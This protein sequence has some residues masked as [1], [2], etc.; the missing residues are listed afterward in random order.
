MIHLWHLPFDLIHTLSSVVALYIRLSRDVLLSILSWRLAFNLL[1]ASYI[2]LSRC[3][4]HPTYSPSRTFDLVLH[5]IYS[6]L[7]KLD[8]FLAFYIRLSSCYLHLIN[9][10]RLTFDLVVPSYIRLSYSVLHRITRSVLHWNYSS[11]LTSQLLMSV[12]IRCDCVV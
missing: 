1:L 7:L 6:W 2:R 4:L 11:D 5:S 8:F 10:W 3:V 12:Y 9:S